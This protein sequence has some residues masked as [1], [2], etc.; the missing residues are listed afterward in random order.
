MGGQLNTQ[1]SVFREKLIEHLFIGE[2][3]KYS[4]LQHGA[5][6]EISYPSIDR[7]GHD[8]VLEANGV[9]RHIQLKTSSINSTT[10]TQTVHVGLQKKP[11]GCVIWVRFN[12]NTLALGPFH[13]FGG[14]PGKPMQPIEN[15]AVAKH[16]K[17]NAVGIKLDRPNLRILQKAKFKTVLTIEALYA[18][19]FIDSISL[20]KSI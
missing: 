4:W 10:A 14:L 13:F 15:F 18:S 6:L 7:T 9:T 5:T 1:Q 16:T 20:P 12:P 11:S 2:L 8:V 3:L 17:A 19:L